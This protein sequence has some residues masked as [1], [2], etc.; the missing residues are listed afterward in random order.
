MFINL[1][2]IKDFIEFAVD[3]H[4][5][6]RGLFIPGSKLPIYNSSYLK[7]KNIKLCLLSLSPES[8]RKVINNNKEFIRSGGR[9]FSI[10]PKSNYALQIS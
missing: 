1:M 2:G 6:K 10:F 5:N 7:K 9:F 3:D 8:E 4:P